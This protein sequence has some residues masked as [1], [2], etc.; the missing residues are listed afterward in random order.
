[1]SSQKEPTRV[2]KVTY[3]LRVDVGGIIDSKGR[4]VVKRETWFWHDY[5]DYQTWSMMPNYLDKPVPQHSIDKA[6]A[7]L[8]IKQVNVVRVYKVRL[9]TTTEEEDV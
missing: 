7:V 3:A 9:E 5:P 6:K 4:S 2:T 8:G 1:M